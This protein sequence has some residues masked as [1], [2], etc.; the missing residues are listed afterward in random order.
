M[1]VTI[2]VANRQN[3]VERADSGFVLGERS[4]VLLSLVQ[5][6]KVLMWACRLWR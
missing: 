1:L 2:D 4:F 3:Y 6:S 5:C